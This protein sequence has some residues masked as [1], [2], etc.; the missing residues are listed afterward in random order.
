MLQMVV[1]LCYGVL[2]TMIKYRLNHAFVGPLG[3]HI[4]P[5]PIPNVAQRHEAVGIKIAAFR[6][7][8]GGVNHLLVHRHKHHKRP[9]I[10]ALITRASHGERPAF[11]MGIPLGNGFVIDAQCL[12]G[13]V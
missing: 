10:V 13:W 7:L 9:S 2:V 12:W 6:H 1:C 5:I 11:A 8:A 4:F 3:I